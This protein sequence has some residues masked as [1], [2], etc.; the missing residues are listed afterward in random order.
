MHVYISVALKCVILATMVRE[1]RLIFIFFIGGD[2]TFI[3]IFSLFLIRRTDRLICKIAD[4]HDSFDNGVI[5]IA[6]LNVVTTTCK[7]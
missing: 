5:A 1:K 6:R 7:K 2:G 3:L 4:M